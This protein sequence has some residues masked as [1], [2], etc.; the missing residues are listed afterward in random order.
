[1]SATVWSVC[2]APGLIDT[3]EKESDVT[4]A[5]EKFLELDKESIQKKL[6]LKGTLYQVV[7]TKVEKPQADE[8]MT[9]VSENGLTGLI[10]LEQDTRRYY[11]YGNFA[12]AVLGFA[13]DDNHGAYGLESYYEKVLA[14][15]PGRVVSMKNSRGVDMDLQYSQEYAAKDGDSLVLTI[16][17]TIQ[18][19]LEKN[20]E[21]ALP[22][23]KVRNRVTGVVMDVKT[24]RGARDGLQ[25]RL[26]PQQPLRD[27]RRQ[28][29]RGARKPQDGRHQGAVRPGAAGG[30]V[31]PVAQLRDLRPL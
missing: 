10:F 12:S 9:F 14:G 25:A 13:N 2:V 11:P 26:R 20:L 15:T 27:P 18:H 31:R 23:H 21:I 4:A 1:M 19:F 7:K 3:P 5:L 17:E 28:K 6:A 16:D 30:M 24:G 8:L 29:A 22:E